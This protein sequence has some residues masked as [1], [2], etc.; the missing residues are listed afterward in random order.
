MPMNVIRVIKSGHLGGNFSHALGRVVEEGKRGFE[1][2]K[3]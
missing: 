2:A 1:M 3:A